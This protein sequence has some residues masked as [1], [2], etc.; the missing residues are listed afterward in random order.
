MKLDP[1][2]VA[3]RSIEIQRCFSSSGSA[4]LAFLDLPQV[5]RIGQIARLANMLRRR[6]I[7]SYT[8]F[9]A[10]GALLGMQPDTIEK[11]L[12]MME[13]FTWLSVTKDSHGE[14]REIEDHVPRMSEVLSTLG[15]GYAE[16]ASPSTPSLSQTERASVGALHMCAKSPCTIE[17][18]RSELELDEKALQ[19]ALTLGDAGRYLEYLQLADDKQALWS[20]VYYYNKYD[21]MK[22]FFQRQ[23]VEGLEPI[24]EALELCSQNV[25][26]PLQLL[27]DQQ[28]RAAIAGVKS[29]IILPITLWM[30]TQTGRQ[31]YTFL[32]PPLAKFEDSDPNG[33]VYEKPKVLLAAFRLGENF[34]PTTKIR[35]PR[36]VVDR[37]LRDGKLGIPHSAAFDQYR[38]PASRGLLVLKEEERRT[39]YGE[40][41]TGWTPHLIKSEENIKALEIVQSLLVPSSERISGTL[42]E[43]VKAADDVLKQAL[44]CLESLEFR[45]SPFSKSLSAD[46]KLQREAERMALTMHGG[47]YE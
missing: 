7:I 13:R 39:V 36:M 24:G 8:S 34:A 21:T 27:P 43:D 2:W 32:F 19:K 10:L 38:V 17:S 15:G 5:M 3:L 6:G 42:T 46:P 47:Q 12:G 45:G 26:T 40:T 9:K 44:T 25:G 33:Q 18:I 41:Y 1:S 29:G 37:L 22:K 14:I 23:T 28:R 30:P 16:E 20:P 11:N 35:S 31:D 4:Q